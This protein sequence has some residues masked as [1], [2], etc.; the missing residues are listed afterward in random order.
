MALLGTALISWF[1]VLPLQIRGI[2]DNPYVG[3][4]VFVAL[5]AIFFAGLL[6][7]VGVYLSRRQIRRDR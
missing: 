7:P 1:F 3:I 6:I 4:V 2:V 5:P